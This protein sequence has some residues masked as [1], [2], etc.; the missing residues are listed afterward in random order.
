METGTRKHNLRNQKKVSYGED[1]QNNDMDISTDEEGILL[2]NLKEKS[3]QLKCSVCTFSTK[4]TPNLKIHM[5][6]KHKENFAMHCKICYYKTTRKID[7]MMHN[8]EKHRSGNELLYANEIVQEGNEQLDIIEIH[9]TEKEKGALCNIEQDN[10]TMHL[11]SEAKKED[12]TEED[13]NSISNIEEPVVDINEIGSNCDSI[14]PQAAENYVSCNICSLQVNNKDE[15]ELHMEGSH[16]LTDPNKTKCKDC[17]NLK[18]KNLDIAREAVEEKAM[19]HVKEAE[20]DR[21][22]QQL[23]KASDEVKKL[24]QEL[25]SSDKKIADYQDELKKAKAELREIKVEK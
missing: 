8:N 19:R 13:P 24:K 10:H 9:D 1:I 6:K 18:A 2:S 11:D 20:I 12:H 15:L 16:A 14:F 23:R 5:K 21:K 7:M 22:T 25:V 4:R 3:T 17:K